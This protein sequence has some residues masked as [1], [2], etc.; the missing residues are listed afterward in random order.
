MASLRYVY[1]CFAADLAA[2]GNKTLHIL[3]IIFV[4]TFSLQWI[5]IYPI[6]GKY[7]IWHEI[8]LQS[9][10]KHFFLKPLPSYVNIL[11]EKFSFSQLG[12][13]NVKKIPPIFH[14]HKFK[15]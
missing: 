3:V 1:V 6:I 12:I 4:V 10:K 8:G 13:K 14:F 5:I 11:P 15:S 2:A 9:D 7:L